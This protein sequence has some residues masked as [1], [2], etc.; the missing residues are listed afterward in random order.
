MCLFCRCEWTANRESSLA[1]AGCRSCVNVQLS[2]FLMSKVL[3]QFFRKGVLE[4]VW[5][6][7]V[8][9]FLRHVSKGMWGL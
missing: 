2:E 8:G 3:P 4:F 9:T 1:E 7:F 6:F 5:N